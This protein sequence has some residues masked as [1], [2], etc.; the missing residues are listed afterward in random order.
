[1]SNNFDIFFSFESYTLLNW[2]HLEQVV[3]TAVYTCY[4]A[5]LPVCFESSPC[6]HKCNMRL[7]GGCAVT[8]RRHAVGLLN[9]DEK[10]GKNSYFCTPCSSTSAV[11]RTAAVGQVDVVRTLHR[12]NA[13]QWPYKMATSANRG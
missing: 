2:R 11:P 9:S 7:T 1:V 3:V 8:S 12:N 6:T 5:S 13:T 4:F 10:C